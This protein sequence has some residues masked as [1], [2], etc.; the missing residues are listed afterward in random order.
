MMSISHLTESYCSPLMDNCVPIRS[1]SLE[2]PGITRLTSEKLLRRCVIYDH[3]TLLCKYLN[4]CGQSGLSL[5]RPLCAPEELVKHDG[6]KMGRCA[7]LGKY[8]VLRRPGFEML[9]SIV[10]CFSFRPRSQ[11]GSSSDQ[12]PNGR[13]R[14]HFP[15]TYTVRCLQKHRVR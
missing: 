2:N 1:S 10:I 15:R 6:H 4:L 5:G 3:C 8:V 9:N 13:K 14:D 7:S 11:I 12:L